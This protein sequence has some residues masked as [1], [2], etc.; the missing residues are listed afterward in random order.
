MHIA[1]IPPQ[2]GPGRVLVR[3][4]RS[5]SVPL[6]AVWIMALLSS[7]LSPC[8]ASATTGPAIRFAPEKDYP[9]FVFEDELGRL[10]GLSMDMLRALEPSLGHPL[11]IQEPRPLARILELAQSGEVDLISSLR[12]TPER[13]AFLSFSD[14]YVNVPAV[15]VVRT[16][17]PR[18]ALKEL[19]T[20]PVGV[21]EG[22]AVQSVMRSRYPVVRWMGYPDDQAALRALLLGELDGV[23]A[24][25]A[26]V[27]YLKDVHAWRDIEIAHP[28]GFDYALSFAW[29]H[30]RPDVGLA[31]RSA[32]RQMNAQQRRELIGR[33]MP[34]DALRYTDPR[35]TWLQAL[36]AA[37]VLA[38]AAYL[39]RQRSRRQ[40][41]PTP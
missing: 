20:R 3:T 17:S 14:P 22:Y 19:G 10:Q 29:P 23:V 2:G 8:A 41:S 27:Q 12:P 25:A 13:S 36:G 18:R 11:Q 28:V 33:W 35:R 9:P 38:F 6:L 4:R 37:L 15:L 16:G 21:G 1:A 31:I 39:W 30:Q 24:D 34:S 32:M 5:G 40:A 26:S 7:A